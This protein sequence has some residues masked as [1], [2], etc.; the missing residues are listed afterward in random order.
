LATCHTIHTVECERGRE[1]ERERE[2]EKARARGERERESKGWGVRCTGRR[3]LQCEGAR[4][5]AQNESWG[6]GFGLR[7][8][9]GFRVW[10]EV[11]F[12]I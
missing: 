11:G 8:G 4:Y 10:V 6:L 12:R 7:L 3:G 5:A 9:L 1:R 2:R